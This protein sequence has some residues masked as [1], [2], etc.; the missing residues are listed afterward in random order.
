MLDFQNRRELGKGGQR[1]GGRENAIFS[2]PPPFFFCPNAHL[3]SR[4]TLPN[5]PLLLIS[6]MAAIAL[7]QNTVNSLVSDHPWGTT[8]WSLTGGGHLRED[9]QNKP[10]TGLIS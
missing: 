2:P 10:N 3:V 6:K 5:P 8:K 4:T 9:Q 1:G 7:N